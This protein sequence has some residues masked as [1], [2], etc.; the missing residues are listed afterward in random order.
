MKVFETAPP[1]FGD[2]HDEPLILQ[3][4]HK[5][6]IMMCVGDA[7]AQYSEIRDIQLHDSTEKYKKS[8]YMGER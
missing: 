1:M 4:G 5:S 8:T 7:I 6:K 3:K 2:Y